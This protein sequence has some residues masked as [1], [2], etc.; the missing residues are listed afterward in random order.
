M[1]SRYWKSRYALGLGCAIAA[2]SLGCEPKDGARVMG[3][4]TIG[5]ETPLVKARV[6]ARSKE[7]GMWATG[8]TDVEGK[9]ILS[10]ETRGEFLPNGTYQVI[11]V[12]DRGDWDHPSPPTISR[13]YGNVASSGIELVVDDSQEKTLELVLDAP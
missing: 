11:V 12:E 3:R 1:G 2:V 5:G 10:S 13:K 8:M 9:F 6:T 4:A 7:N